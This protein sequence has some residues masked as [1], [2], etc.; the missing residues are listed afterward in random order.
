MIVDLEQA[1]LPP[2][3]EAD[4]CIVGAGAA[5]I[6]IALAFVGGNHRVIVL[7]SG[8]ERPEPDVEALLQSDLRGLRCATALDGRAR[9]FGGST[10]MWA[11]QALAFDDTVFAARPW[12]PGSGWPLEADEI[13]RHL[14]AA[15]RLLQLGEPRADGWPGE[16]PRP[17]GID[18]LERTFS[19][20]SPAPNFARTHRQTLAAAVNVTVV[21]HA[22]ATRLATSGDGSGVEA[23]EARSLGGRAVRVRAR[24]HVVCCGGI[25]T[26]R[27]LLVSGVG[28]AHDMVGRCFQEHPHLLLP[29]VGGSRRAIARHFHSHRVHGVRLYGKLAASADLQRAE[30]ILNV[31]GDVTYDVH[32]N[33]AV[34]AGR[35]FVRAVREHRPR[36][37]AAH[38]GAALAHPNQL[39]RAAFA[40]TV[41]GRKAT[42]GFGQPYLCVQVENAPRQK[43]R[44]MLGDSPDALGLPR[45]VVDW[46]IGDLELRSIEVFARRVDAGLGAHDLGRLD[47]SALPSRLDLTELSG[48]LAGGCHHLGGT[49]MADAPAAGVVDRDLR[50]HGVPNLHIASASVFPTGGW[51]NPTLTILALALR[52]ADRLERELA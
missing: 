4:L 11:G 50:V 47:L 51:G 45:A 42:E 16:L 17:P 38:G 18:G 40:S 7:E 34:R 29:L 25:E 21:L 20:F 10:T 52:L 19:A 32:A 31:G 43:S 5:G 13:R 35:R 1:S 27:L 36:A 9:I 41:L 49:R 2:E 8:G 12:V 6:A 22:N 26:P 3:L 37:V 39:A 30:R 23:V 28:N 24:R 44:V 33:E 15:E 14:P 46:R 48:M